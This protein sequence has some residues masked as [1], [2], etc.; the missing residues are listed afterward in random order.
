MFVDFKM[1][2]SS[3]SRDLIRTDYNLSK[4]LKQVALD[5]QVAKFVSIKRERDLQIK[6]QGYGPS[7]LTESPESKAR[8]TPQVTKSGSEYMVRI[9]AFDEGPFSFFVQL[10]SRDHEYQKFQ[11]DLQSL[12][13]GMKRL[14]A[15]PSPGTICLA[16]IKE[17]LYRVTIVN[18]EERLKR[19]NAVVQSL[20]NG[21]KSI[22]H[23]KCLYEIPSIVCGELAFAKQFKLFGYEK[24]CVGHLLKSEV[25][26]YFQHITKNKLLKLE[27]VSDLGQIATCNLFD[28]DED[29]LQ[30]IHRWQPHSPRYP[31]QEKLSESVYQVFISSTKSPNWFH[32]QLDDAAKITQYKN[33][34]ESLRVYDPIPLRNPKVNDACVAKLD[35]FQMRALVIGKVTSQILKVRFVDIGYEEDLEM[36]EVKVMLKEFMKLPPFAFRCCLKGFEDVVHVK[37]A[38]A[39]EFENVCKNLKDFKIRV[40]KKTGELHVVELA[41]SA[42]DNINR[43]M[44]EVEKD[45]ANHSDWTEKPTPSHVHFKK[46]RPAYDAMM[47]FQ[48][49]PDKS[50]DWD[51]SVAELRNSTSK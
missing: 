28:K 50:K 29:I 43:R 40:V 26:F 48:E 14:S 3:I 19:N 5:T 7:T 6:E 18:S 42:D 23:L 13:N 38:I 15:I 32:V 33:L 10:T 9:S 12:K 46:R 17:H 21:M 27:V 16:L 45:K 44:L 31:P 49:S 2:D 51:E 39:H 20:E 30:K 8:V 25:N 34:L 41:D 37:E 47:S 24:G 22:V 1:G 35:N 4:V 36:S 11:V